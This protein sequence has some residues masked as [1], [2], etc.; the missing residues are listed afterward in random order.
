MAN[1]Q[2]INI[3]WLAEHSELDIQA[4]ERVVV[5]DCEGRVIARGELKHEASGWNRA[6]S[7]NGFP[8]STWLAIRDVECWTT[9]SMAEIVYVYREVLET[10]ETF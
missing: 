1:L 2:T 3:E 10:S 9:N 8:I 4:G 5:C 7:V 6:A